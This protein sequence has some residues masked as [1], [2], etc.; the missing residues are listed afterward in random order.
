[1]NLNEKIIK[2]AENFNKKNLM[3]NLHNSIK[4]LGLA[5]LGLAWLKSLNFFLYT[6]RTLSP[7]RSRGLGRGFFVFEGV[8]FNPKSVRNG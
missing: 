7:M 1:M 2:F 8:V 6:E 3:K 5:W 4:S